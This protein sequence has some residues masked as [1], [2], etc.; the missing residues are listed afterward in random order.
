[1]SL[2]S[3]FTSLSSEEGFGPDFDD[4][5]GPPEDE[6][7]LLPTVKSSYVWLLPGL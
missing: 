7:L 5:N 4:S 6:A 2:W 3:V 1:M